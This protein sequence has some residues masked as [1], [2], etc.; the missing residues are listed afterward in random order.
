MYLCVRLRV[1]AG[2]RLVCVYKGH[3]ASMWWQQGVSL[4]KFK[5]EETRRG[6]RGDEVRKQSRNKE[7]RGNKE[8]RSDRG[9]NEERR[10]EEK[11]A[12]RK[13]DKGRR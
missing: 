2:V 8:R 10:E 13:R 11:K 9:G 6:E 12:N 7:G 1:S 5:E 3:P 4:Q